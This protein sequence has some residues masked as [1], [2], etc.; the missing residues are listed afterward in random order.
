MQPVEKE[1]LPAEARWA[2]NEGCATGTIQLRHF[3]TLRGLPLWIIAAKRPPI[4]GAMTNQSEDERMRNVPT[5]GLPALALALAA[6]PPVALAQD[7]AQPAPAPAPTPA[8]A[9]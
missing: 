1:T 2:V 6:S 8:A 9:P 5:I 7:A 4:V 3:N